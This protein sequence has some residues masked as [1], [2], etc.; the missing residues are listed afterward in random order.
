[1][2]LQSTRGR[3]GTL[4]MA[5]VHR[6]GRT[7]LADTFFQ[8][9]L[10]VMK[11]RQTEDG[12]VCVYL[13]TPTGGVVQGDSYQTDLNLSPSTCVTFTTQSATKVY[14]MPLH[15]ARQELRFYVGARG[16]LEYLPDPVILFQDADFEQ[17]VSVF[18]EAGAR[19]ILQDIVMPGRLGRGEMLAFRRYATHLDV[20]DTDGLLIHDAACICPNVEQRLCQ[21]GALEG[22]PVWGSGYLL[23]DVDVSRV[24]ASDLPEKIDCLI[25]QD[26][27]SIGGFSTL[28]RNGLAIRMLAVNTTTILNA[29][30]SAWNLLKKELFGLGPVDL[31]K[32]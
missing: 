21:L 13:L 2:P 7:V 22:F 1:M 25:N 17:R 9:P 18:L 28:R 3:H 11:P 14:G 12:G 16:F 19:V 31:R 20:T 4:R 8:A 32:Y 27:P 23:G 10:Q 15:S 29:F 6:N 24:I 5:F 30:Q 26:N